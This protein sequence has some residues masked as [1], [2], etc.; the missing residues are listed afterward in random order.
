MIETTPDGSII[1]TGKDDTRLYQ[2]ITLAHA[3]ALEINTGMKVSRTSALQGAKNLGIIPADKRGNKKAALKAT[4][5]KIKESR[6]DYEPTGS[7]AKAVA[8]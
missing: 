1:V 3:L 8:A 7:V 4:I 2:L 5:A 6:P